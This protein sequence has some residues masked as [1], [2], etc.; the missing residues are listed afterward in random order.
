M[1]AIMVIFGLYQMSLIKILGMER[2]LIFLFLSALATEGFSQPATRWRGESGNG[3]YSETGLL[4]KWPV[5]GPEELWSYEKL[6]TGH[7]SPVVSQGFLYVSGMVEETGML[8]KFK[9]DGELIWTKAYGPEFNSSYTGSRG[10]PVLAG[11]K[12]YLVSG[13]GVLYCMAAGDASILWTKALFKDFDGKNITW[14]VNETPVVDGDI[15]YATPGGRNNNVVALNRHSGDLIWSS[16]G[17]GELSAYCSP[18]LIDHNGRKILITHT[19]SYLIG[20]DALN[21][22]LLWSHKQPNDYSV[23]ANTPIYQNG[24]LFYFSGYGQ[25]GGSLILSMDGSSI[26]QSWFSKK[27]DSRMSGAVVVD[28]YIYMSGDYAREWR[29]VEWDT[30]KEMYASTEL[31][32]GVVIYADGMLYCYTDRGELALVKADPSEFKVVSKTKVSKGSEQHWAHP[33][34]DD[35]VLYLRHG[36]AVIAYKVK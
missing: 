30:G 5:S 26:T 31:G 29:C 28:G 35:G 33:I 10:S 34:I 20:L 2:L 6:G 21:G 22:D 14:G 1:R 11:D 24:V 32:K 18:L 13:N 15:I 23:H 7:S 27:L 3:I 9:L 16:K 19:A 17:K 4:K 25:G 36:S 8:F 12:I